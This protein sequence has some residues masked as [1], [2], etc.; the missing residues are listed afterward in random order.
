MINEVQ[1]LDTRETE[2][3]KGGVTLN[4]PCFSK[5]MPAVRLPA[6]GGARGETVFWLP[7]EGGQVVQFNENQ[8]N[9]LGGASPEQVDLS[10]ID[11]YVHGAGVLIK[12]MA[13]GRYQ[14]LA[15]QDIG[16][17]PGKAVRAELSRSLVVDAKELEMVTR[18]V[19]GVALTIDSLKIEAPAVP[20]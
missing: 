14:V 9:S 13:D 1:Q 15:N 3:N 10:A 11:E 20:D 18:K 12:P 16:A 5:D 2:G 7:A 19:L 6:E 8:L 17:F 4:I